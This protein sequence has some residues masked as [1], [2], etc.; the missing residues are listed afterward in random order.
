MGAFSRQAAEFS[1]GDRVGEETDD[2]KP[3]IAPEGQEYSQA[4]H[5][6]DQQ[7]SDYRQKEL[8]GGILALFGS[9]ASSANSRA[10]VWRACRFGKPG[11]E[12]LAA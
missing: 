4:E 5:D 9:C 10:E 3:R 12:R 8:H 6:T 1:E 11:S 7:I 2:Q